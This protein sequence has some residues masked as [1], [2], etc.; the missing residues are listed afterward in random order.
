[1]PLLARTHPHILLK[2]SSLLLNAG[3]DFVWNFATAPLNYKRKVLKQQRR[4]QQ[5]IGS[6]SSSDGNG[7]ESKQR[8]EPI[9]I[10]SNFL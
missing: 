3:R 5:K 2:M 4:E 7:N 9:T 1:M 8:Y 6:L 10:S